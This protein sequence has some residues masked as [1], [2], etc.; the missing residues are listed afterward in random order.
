MS[1]IT[2]CPACGTLFNMV[3]DQLKVSQGWVRCGQ[4]ADV[5]DA[6]LHLQNE[7]AA[8]EALA[9]QLLASESPPPVV[10]ADD[11]S[12]DSYAQDVAAALKTPDKSAASNI[13]ARAD[14][15]LATEAED[16]KAL[17]LD[18]D[19][20]DISTQVATDIPGDA[21]GDRP[22]DAVNDVSFVRQARQQAFWRKPA[23]RVGLGLVAVLLIGLLAAQY[24]VAKRDSLAAAEPR[25]KPGLQMLC[26]RLVCTVGPVRQ[27]EAIVI[28][29][30][31]FNKVNDTGNY[32]LSFVVKNTGAAPVAM[33]SLE[34]TLT[35]TQDQP[36]LRRVFSPAQLGSASSM[37]APGSDW[38][39]AASL[40][41][42]ANP[43]SPDNASPGV[44]GQV[45][46]YR[47]LAFYP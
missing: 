32:R 12:H 5:F 38:S 45:A 31:S 28:D 44:V 8:R 2:R 33:P 43:S 18:D 37:L 34:V 13:D 47:L 25:L 10:A 22:S 6:T 40:Q 15:P 46:G 26:E 39:G 35:D 1:L 3:A 14:L 7:R 24:A 16:V 19:R 9:A 17:S 29:N 41:V 11:A 42:A 23:V 4:C 21:S 36:V 27:I 20:D 30:S